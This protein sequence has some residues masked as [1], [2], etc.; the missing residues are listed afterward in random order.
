MYQVV[1]GM[2]CYPK[3]YFDPIS[4]H[5]Y[6]A[7]CDQ[8]AF[9]VHHSANIW[10]KNNIK[11]KKIKDSF[12]W[13]DRL[14]E[15]QD[16]WNYTYKF[17]KENQDYLWL[18]AR[19]HQGK[20]NAINNTVLV[21]GSSHALGGIDVYCFKNAINC[22]MHGQDLYY[23]FLCAKDILDNGNKGIRTCFIVLGY[24]IAFQDLSKGLKFGRDKIAK[25]YFPLFQDSRHWET[26]SIYDMWG[27]MPSCREEEKIVIEEM[28]LDMM[29]E[30]YQYYSDMR[31]RYPLYNF[32]G[33]KWKDLKPDEKD[34]FGQKRATDHNKFINYTEVF[35]ENI[36]VIEDYIHLLE[37]NGIKPVLV[38][39]PFTEAYNRYVLKEIKEAVREMVERVKVRIE[40]IDFNEGNMFEDDDFIDTDHMNGRGAYK[41][42]M[43]LAKRYGE[44]KKW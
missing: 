41:M 4:S 15:N 1:D 39:P 6:I 20:T 21:T 26:P 40:F 32:C 18:K 17:L 8:N 14:M 16:Y 11:F 9:S 29:R 19:V 7:P 25:I 23:D 30:R 5:F 2:A 42:S 37:L 38:I 10:D 43:I 3:D 36:L 27:K 44:Q 12:T 31:I 35:E 24:Y 22:S 33:C 28:A 13:S 34:T